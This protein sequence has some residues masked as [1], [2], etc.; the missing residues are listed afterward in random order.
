MDVVSDKKG[1]ISL[2]LRRAN[3][4]F[5]VIEES[6]D[7]IVLERAVLV[8]KRELWLYE[9]ESAKKSVE[10]GLEQARQGK[11]KKNL[12]TYSPNHS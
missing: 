12:L 3:Q 9:N 8:P 6:D 2:G 1:R 5:I 4:R 7:R 11:I 10:N